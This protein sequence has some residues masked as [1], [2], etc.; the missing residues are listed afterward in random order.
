MGKQN[1]VYLYAGILLGNKKKWSVDTHCNIDEPWKRAKW[2][3]ESHK[4][5][6]YWIL[7]C[8]HDAWA[9]RVSCLYMLHSLPWGL[10][11]T[12]YLPSF[13]EIN[14]YIA[15][16]SLQRVLKS[17]DIP[18]VWVGERISLRYICRVG[19]INHKLYYYTLKCPY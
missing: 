9:H 4:K 6:T 8:I 12:F 16:K 11:I 2:K 15:A 19:L 14:T 7:I 10:S 13:P 17:P 5:I 3:E 18:P 1:L